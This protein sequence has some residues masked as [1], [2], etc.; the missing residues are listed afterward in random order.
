[1]L[2]KQIESRVNTTPEIKKK[3]R[4]MVPSPLET[5]L[6]GMSVGGSFRRVNGRDHPREMQP[7]GCLGHLAG[8]LRCGGG[9][10]D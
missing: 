1:M 5:C 6:W 8:R 3:E 9:M 10:V 7:T 4:T 2:Y